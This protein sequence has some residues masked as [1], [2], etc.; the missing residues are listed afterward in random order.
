[1]FLNSTPLSVFGKKS[2]FLCDRRWI[3]LRYFELEAVTSFSE[4]AAFAYRSGGLKTYG[5]T[6]WTRL[7]LRMKMRLLLL[8]SYLYSKVL[9]Q[10]LFMKE[11]RKLFALPRGFLLVICPVQG[12]LLKRKV[13]RRKSSVLK[14]VSVHGKAT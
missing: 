1:M 4:G 3:L 11:K 10:Y 6:P 13:R 2:M 14:D 7:L 9:F 8:D 5:L 12:F